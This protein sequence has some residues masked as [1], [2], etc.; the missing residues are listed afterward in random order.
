[1]ISRT[2]MLVL[3]V[4][5]ALL[6]AHQVSSEPSA[7][8]PTPA[9]VIQ[10]YVEA[11]GG[12]KLDAITSIR[13]HCNI[14]E[15]Q[16]EHPV[17][18]ETWVWIPGRW[19]ADYRYDSGISRISIHGYRAWS[20]TTD[21]TCRWFNETN[22]TWYRE[23]TDRSPEKP[24]RWLNRIES[25]RVAGIETVSG[26]D[27]Y[28]M[29]FYRS[30]NRTVVRWFDVESGLM[31]RSVFQGKWNPLTRTFEDYRDVDGVKFPFRVSVKF[32]DS[33]SSYV[34]QFDEIVINEAIDEEQFTLPE[35]L[36]PD[37]EDLLFQGT[38]TCSE[39]SK[40]I[41]GV[42]VAIVRNRD[43][44]V[45][46]AFDERLKRPEYVITDQQG[47]FQVYSSDA[48]LRDLEEWRVEFR[49]AESQSFFPARYLVTADDQPADNIK[50]ILE[51]CR[52]LRGRIINA[53]SGEGVQGWVQLQEKHKRSRRG[54]LLV[55][56]TDRGRSTDENGDFLLPVRPKTQNRIAVR[57]RI[58][59]K[60]KLRAGMHHEVIT[61]EADSLDEEAAFHLTPV[62][63][64][65][66]AVVTEAGKPVSSFQAAGHIPHPEYL[67]R[68][69][70]GLNRPYI[71]SREKYSNAIEVFG[72]QKGEIRELVLL[73]KDL[74]L[75]AIRKL[76]LPE[77]GQ[78]IEPVVMR[79][80][81][82]I[83]GRVT[84]ENAGRL[85]DITFRVVYQGMKVSGGRVDDGDGSFQL[86]NIPPE[87][88]L[89]LIVHGSVKGTV[90]RRPFE[91]TL[92][93]DP[94][95]T[96]QQIDLG[97]VDLH[98]ICSIVGTVTDKNSD[99]PMAGVSVRFKVSKFMEQMDGF[100]AV[101]T[102]DE[103]QFQL[104]HNQ[105]GQR[106]LPAIDELK[107][108][109]N[110]AGFAETTAKIPDRPAG[111]VP[112]E[113]NIELDGSKVLSGKV[114]NAETGE[115]IEAEINFIPLD[116]SRQRGRSRVAA[117]KTDGKFAIHSPFEKGMIVVKAAEY[118]RYRIASDFRPGHGRGNAQRVVSLSD[119]KPDEL[120]FRL[121]PASIT[122]VNVV[123]DQGR[124]VTDFLAYGRY[125]QVSGTKT[126]NYE[127][128][129]AEHLGSE[130]VEVFDLEDRSV[131]RLI[132]VVK[133]DEKLIGARVCTNELNDMELRA[134]LVLQKSASL[135][136]KV[137]SHKI[138]QM[139]FRLVIPG[140]ENQQ[141]IRVNQHANIQPD[142]S[143]Q[144][145]FVPPGFSYEL[146]LVADDARDP[147]GLKRPDAGKRILIENVTAD[148][149]IDLG[150]IKLEEKK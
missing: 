112:L 36:R 63:S 143:F 6:L 90:M 2:M 125:R 33:D 83:I 141:G 48:S 16:G 55:S 102:N 68:H 47:R 74:G 62:G 52:L 58:S 79:S 145:S 148:Q 133:P 109:P 12:D 59:G 139:Y 20:R 75:F 31:V 107:I 56:M 29:E 1:M 45:V 64:I 78:V 106:G 13:T 38:V 7:A 50:V 136:G 43:S 138:G 21:K 60:F 35:E 144:L 70:Q 89:T 44:H 39:T 72:L 131:P 86:I 118:G 61:L 115:P 142:G 98:R 101:T 37:P 96:G 42:E 49:P 97:D 41:P 82:S 71:L 149:Q 19:T 32:T 30:R 87:V 105:S 147:R 77:N 53:A 80:A 134:P 8:L 111:F 15:F 9:E 46:D 73:Q 140:L 5:P 132:M 22:S 81:A 129:N 3:L 110:Q 92:Q 91:Q 25:I 76:R 23:V 65:S 126:L 116:G 34:M 51:P 108:T 104:L 150:K 28:R 85:A 113:M 67:R 88:P 114:I 128:T 124:P 95:V 26:K 10:R 84:G 117:N 120:V 40:P 54:D 69:G 17:Y 27:A 99:K 57:G 14:T 146:H 18:E 135:R 4:Q 127:R 137:T 123:N 119:V 24:A 103:G 94:L 122:K 93:I 130:T 66:I 11:L 100:Q 121:Q